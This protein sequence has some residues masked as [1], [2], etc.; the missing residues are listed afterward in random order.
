MTAEQAQA[1]AREVATLTRLG[2]EEA[3]TLMGRAARWAGLGADALDAEIAAHHAASQ[4]APRTPLLG[5][6]ALLATAM[7]EEAVVAGLDPAAREG[8]EAKLHGF[9]P[10]AG[11]SGGLSAWAPEPPPRAAVEPDAE[12]K[13]AADA[14]A[15]RAA[16]VAEL[17]KNPAL[18]DVKHK[19]HAAVV[20]QLAKLHGE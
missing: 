3:A 14:G 10:V 16:A 19:D 12:Q 17:R 6:T 20:Q 2:P 4:R 1:R 8:Y 9:G 13:R 18:L 7:R 11:T 5:A 15:A